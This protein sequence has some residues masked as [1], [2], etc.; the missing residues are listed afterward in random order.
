MGTIQTRAQAAELERLAR[1]GD[2]AAARALL[3]GQEIT[4]DRVGEE[5]YAIALR[6]VLNAPAPTT[7][8]AARS[9]RVLGGELPAGL[10][11][12]Q[13]EPDPE[14]ARVYRCAYCADLEWVNVTADRSH[15]MFGRAVPCRE[16]VP[17]EV[18]LA[19]FGVPALF[20]GARLEGLAALPGKAE[21][22]RA[23]AAWDGTSSVVL[24][25]RGE[26]LDATFGTGKTTLAAAMV[27][28]LV[29]RR[30]VSVRWLT[31][32]SFLDGMKRLFD[33]DGASAEAWAAQVAA[34]PVLVLDDLGASQATEWS[35]SRTQALINARYERGLLTIV[36]T[37]YT[38][39]SDVEERYDGR[40]ASRMRAWD[41]IVV[42]GRDLRG[43]VIEVPHGR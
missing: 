33:Q 35:V 37:N 26:A 19:R 1:A 10:P 38:S 43:A 4:P 15:P 14:P 6:E 22:I 24:A 31:H 20:L 18:R 29:E 34:E 16:C 8:G 27:A 7:D 41:W 13:P 40:I 23:C 5:D 39:P 12:T 36:T 17:L 11:P 25:S 9:M 3:A 32:V 21:A 30:Q 42:G 28:R 2:E